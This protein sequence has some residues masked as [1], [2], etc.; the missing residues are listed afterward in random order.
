MNNPKRTLNVR[1]FPV[2]S[3]AGV[4]TYGYQVMSATNTLDHAVGTKISAEVVKDLIMCGTTV[5][6]KAK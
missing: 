3:M 1:Q 2:S 5:N 6:V 4:T